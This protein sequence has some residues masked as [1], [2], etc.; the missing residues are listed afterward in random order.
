M[1]QVRFS[2]NLLIL[3]FLVACNKEVKQTPKLTRIGINGETSYIYNKEGEK[4]FAYKNDYYTNEY[5]VLMKDDTI[6]LGE[7]FQSSI[8]IPHHGFRFYVYKPHPD[9]LTDDSEFYDYQFTPSS[10]GEHDFTGVSVYDSF[11]ISINYK[12]LVKE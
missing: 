4:V 2:L 5:A 12:F 3:S 10:L 11:K 7:K 8:T 1:G 9:T 6:K